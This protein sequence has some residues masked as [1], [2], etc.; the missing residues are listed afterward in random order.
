MKG[1]KALALDY[2]TK[3]IG[4]A[5]GDTE[6]C[7]ASPRGIIENKGS[8]FVI[9]EL[10]KM[11]EEWEVELIIIG[12]P[13][14]MDGDSSN[15]IMAVVQDFVA[16]WEKA[17]DIEIKLFDERLS[18]FEAKELMQSMEENGGRVDRSYKDSLA[19]QIILQRFFDSD[20]N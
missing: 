16:E 5:G 18:T 11:C 15:R 7:L 9:N 14:D 3:R 12:L 8:D 1:K 13:L 2:G 17:S 6:V 19:A 4:V 20:D 10:K